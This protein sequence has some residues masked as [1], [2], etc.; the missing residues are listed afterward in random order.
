MTQTELDEAEIRLR[1]ST[2][3]DVEETRQRARRL[4]KEVDRLRHLV[5][6]NIA[7]LEVGKELRLPSHAAG[8]V[9]KFLS[10]GI[11]LTPASKRGAEYESYLAMSREVM[12]AKR[13]AKRKKTPKKEE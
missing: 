12:R 6:A 1:A 7:N 4:L 5:A 2:V 10:A 8:D 13:S 3:V 11:G 9:I